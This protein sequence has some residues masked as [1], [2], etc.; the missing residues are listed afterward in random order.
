MYTSQE[1]GAKYKREGQGGVRC[2]H[3]FFR[4]IEG[5]QQRGQAV[6]GVVAPPPAGL[7]HQQVR[8]AHHDVRGAEQRHAA[9]GE[10]EVVDAPFSVAAERGAA[11]QARGG[12]VPRLLVGGEGSEVGGGV[13]YASE[14]GGGAGGLLEAY[15]VAAFAGGGD[16]VHRGGQRDTAATAAAADAAAAAAAAAATITTTAAADE[17]RGA[18][19]RARGERPPG[20][21]AG[22]GH[23]PCDGVDGVAQEDGGHGHPPGRGLGHTARERGGSAVGER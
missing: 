14:H 1:R 9:L 11:V 4:R 3:L 8:R 10:Q 13:V 23:R 6:P 22:P 19:T 17:G 5:V 2:L 20:P 16:A 15:G 18:G 7:T 12:Q 21:G